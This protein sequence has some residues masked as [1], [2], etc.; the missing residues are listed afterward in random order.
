VASTCG[1]PSGIRSSIRELAVVHRQGE[2]SPIRTLAEAIRDN[3]PDDV[4]DLLRAAPEGV[5]WVD[6]NDDAERTRIQQQ[7][8]VHARDV[9][10]AASA[11][12]AIT[13]LAERAAAATRVLDQLNGLKVLAALR[14]GRDGV[15]GWNRRID[16]RLRAESG[17]GYSGW[18]TGRPVMVTKNDYVNHVFNGDVGV[19]LAVEDRFQVWFPRSPEPLAIEATRLADIVTQ[20]AMSI[21]KSQ[22]SEFAQV[23][24]AL[25]PPPSRILTRELLYTAVTRAKAAVTIMASEDS[26]RAAIARPVARASGLAVRLAAE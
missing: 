17:I 24:V 3:R 10:A 8:E 18:Y 13:D 14:R 7:V 6:P 15:D 26:V 23:V 2:D 25:P 20:W 21:H 19:A 22:G 11:A 16:Q 1:S 5:V 12:A 9:V 4:I